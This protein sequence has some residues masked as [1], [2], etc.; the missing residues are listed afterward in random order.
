MSS[1]TMHRPSYQFMASPYRERAVQFDD[2]LEPILNALWSCKEGTEDY[3]YYQSKYDHL[4]YRKDQY[5][6]T[7]RLY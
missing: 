3:A 2:M 7:G 6:K 5:I 1:K 4:N